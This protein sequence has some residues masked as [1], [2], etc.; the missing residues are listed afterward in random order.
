MQLTEG[1]VPIV[2]GRSMGCF[3][4]LAFTLPS[5]MTSMPRGTVIFCAKPFLCHTV[6]SNDTDLSTPDTNYTM[7]GYWDRR[8]LFSSAK[9][10]AIDGV[11]S[12]RR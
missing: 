3:H 4:Q 7:D 9:H 11:P 6:T 8:V 1:G 10:L 12:P 5:M 2:T